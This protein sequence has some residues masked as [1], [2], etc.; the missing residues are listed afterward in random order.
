MTS[1]KHHK[2][3][4]SST[5]IKKGSHTP[6][7][8]INT[9]INPTI[10][11]NLFKIQ[12]LITIPNFLETK[13]ANTFYDFLQKEMTDEWWYLSAFYGE[14]K[15]IINNIP[16]NK[17]KV[18]EAKKL[19]N[20]KFIDDEF[21]YAFYR[22]YNNHFPECDCP[23]CKLRKIMSSQEFIQYISNI[24]GLSLEKNTELFLSKY[25]SDCFLNVHNDQGNG[26]IAF[27]IN[28]TRNWKPQYGG[29]F[30]ILSNNRKTVRKIITPQFNS[31][32]I[33]KIPEPNGIPHYVSHVISG[34]KYNRLAIGGW[35][36]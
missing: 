17:S 25:G 4:S 1:R 9:K 2:N 19:A 24:T 26:K 5:R 29:N 7:L 18:I 8:P 36:S 21:S 32:T 3:K 23:E 16:P 12:G 15:V 20:Q 13:F 27:V 33:F 35:F 31:L 10:Y 14:D 22:T 34:V 6:I 30:Y 28:M 11:K